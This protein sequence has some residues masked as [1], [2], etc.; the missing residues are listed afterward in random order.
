MLGPQPEKS[1]GRKTLVLDLDETL[2]H[3]Q[4]NQIKSPDYVIPVNIDGASCNIFVSKRPGV[5]NFLNVM[6][7]YYEVVIFTASLSKYADPLMNQMDVNGVCTM[8][9][10][11]EHCTYLQ[12][13]FTKDMSKIGRNM[14]D[15]M[16]LDNSPSA[17]MLQPEC[18]VPIISWYDD[19]KDR[20]LFDL[21]P[22]FIQ[23]SRINDCREAITRFVKNNSVEFNF[24][25]QVC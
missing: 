22:L 8:R 12:G 18:A 15:A 20:Q 21:I 10:F 13:V 9:L 23:L 7:Q 24:A 17:Y 1:R 25:K 14:K 2:V 19:P 4:F 16:I 6:S 3:S 11:R 5:D